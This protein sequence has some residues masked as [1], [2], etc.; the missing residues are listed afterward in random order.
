[1]NLLSICAQILIATSIGFVWIVR[2]DNIVR[3]FKQYGIPDLLRNVVGAAKIAMSTLL[4]AGIWYDSLVLAPALFIAFMMI[5]A[6][7][8][9]LK[10]KNPWH[11]F[12]PSFLLL[13]LCLF[14]AIAHSNTLKLIY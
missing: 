8:F 11:K 6:Q 14:V 3:E 12:V 9:H 5:C 7:F 13:L 10:A 4:I 2:F 1:M